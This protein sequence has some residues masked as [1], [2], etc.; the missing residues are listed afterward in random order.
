M[1]KAFLFPPAGGFHFI[2]DE[3]VTGGVGF[4]PWC[5]CSLEVSDPIAS[6]SPVFCVPLSLSLPRLNPSDGL[7]W[8]DSSPGRVNCL[9]LLVTTSNELVPGLT[10]SSLRRNSAVRRVLVSAD[11]VSVS[12]WKT[13]WSMAKR[14]SRRGKEKGERMGMKRTSERKKMLISSSVDLM[15]V[16]CHHFFF[17][18]FDN[19]KK[20]PIEPR[21]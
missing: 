3:R 20:G 18:F 2:L 9:L 6:V 1:R 12:V 4:I 8:L 14:I 19:K 16:R 11:R 13:A 21:K 5:C 7:L 15:S 10:C 17:L